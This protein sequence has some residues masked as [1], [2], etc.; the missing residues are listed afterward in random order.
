M[1]KSKLT[2]QQHMSL[3]ELLPH[4]KALSHDDK[5]LLLHALVTQMV[6]DAGL[7]PLDMQNGTVRDRQTPQGLHDSFEA[8]SVLAQALAEQTVVAEENMVVH[9]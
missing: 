8:A 1:E 4:V 2:D 3:N 9:G 5:L 7:T 6:Q